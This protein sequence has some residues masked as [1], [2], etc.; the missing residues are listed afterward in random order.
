MKEENL[1]DD[2]L[3]SED[4]FHSLVTVAEELSETEDEY[5]QQL[6]SAI[7]SYF[8]VVEN[9]TPWGSNVVKFKGSWWT[10]VK[11]VSNHQDG[12]LLSCPVGDDLTQEEHWSD[13]SYLSDMR[14]IDL[15]TLNRMLHRKMGYVVEF[16]HHWEGTISVKK[17]KKE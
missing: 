6:V 9:I 1:V 14:V 8:G 17:T 2:I 5:N 13:V 12:G 11:E 16:K 10:I 3:L 4:G 15:M 7:A